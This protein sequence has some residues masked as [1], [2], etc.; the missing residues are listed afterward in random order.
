MTPG[1]V[2]LAA[3]VGIYLGWFTYYF[4]NLFE[5]IFAHAVYDFIGLVY[6]VYF[7]KDEP[8][9]APL[10]PDPVEPPHVIEPEGEPPVPSSGQEPLP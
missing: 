3:L 7:D 1:Y 9:P 6:L 4:D 10:Q 8:P 2:V 5:A